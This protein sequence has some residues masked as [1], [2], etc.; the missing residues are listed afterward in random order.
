MSKITAWVKIPLK[1]G[2][3]DDA[4]AY[5]EAN[6]HHVAAET[7]TEVYILHVDDKDPDVIYMYERY[8]DQD[9]FNAHV[10]AEWFQKFF[11]GMAEFVSGNAEFTL[12]RPVSGKGL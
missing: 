1:A 9:G 12:L 4:I 7:G 5:F 10:G 3:R 8:S 11:P 6:A 2:V